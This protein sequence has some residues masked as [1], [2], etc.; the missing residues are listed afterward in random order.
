MYTI[1]NLVSRFWE[2]HIAVAIGV[3]ERKSGG[4]FCAEAQGL[5]GSREEAV[6]NCLNSAIDDRVYG[7]D[8]VVN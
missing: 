1:L 6:F 2:V 5:R 4:R 3:W 7:I 8:N